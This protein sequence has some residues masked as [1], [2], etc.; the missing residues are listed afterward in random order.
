MAS[1]EASQSLLSLS[2]QFL[3]L[4]SA[5]RQHSSVDCRLSSVLLWI[6]SRFLSQGRFLYDLSLR[7]ELIFCFKLIASSISVKEGILVPGR[8]H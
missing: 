6:Q 3:L 8:N 4:G 7:V 2:R 1:G 5:V